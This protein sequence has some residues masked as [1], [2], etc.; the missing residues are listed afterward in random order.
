M[1]AT[2]RASLP[3]CLLPSDL[4]GCGTELWAARHI[5]RR[6]PVKA[7]SVHLTMQR[8]TGRRSTSSSSS[9]SLQPVSIERVVQH[10]R[11]NKLTHL[12]QALQ[13]VS[14]TLALV[15]M[16][17]AGGCQA[18]SSPVSGQSGI[19]TSKDAAANAC[20][21]SSSSSS[22]SQPVSTERVLQHFRSSKFP[23]VPQVLQLVSE[24][25]AL[26]WMRRAEGC[27]AHS[28]P[29]GFDIC[30]QSCECLPCVDTGD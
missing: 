28:S 16:R 30:K 27:R 18:H 25:L 12:P 11:S 24:T 6:H 26:V 5:A 21:T 4:H 17:R 19:C 15:W 23:H 8:R 1:P 29:D 9:S 22:S 14:E 20:N 3:K 13:L 7:E 2:G 10:V